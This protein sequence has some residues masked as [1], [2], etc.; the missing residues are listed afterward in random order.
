MKE[1]C[2]QGQ[3]KSGFFLQAIVVLYARIFFQEQEKEEKK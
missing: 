1:Y 3:S 2:W